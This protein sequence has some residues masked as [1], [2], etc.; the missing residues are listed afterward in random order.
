MNALATS[1]AQRREVCQ[2]GMQEVPGKFPWLCFLRMIYADATV[3]VFL[4]F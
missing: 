3:L 2:L 4:S 1:N